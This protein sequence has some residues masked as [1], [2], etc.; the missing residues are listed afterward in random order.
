MFAS[1]ANRGRVSLSDTDNQVLKF[2]KDEIESAID[3]SFTILNTRINQ[4]GTS[5]AKV[6]RLQQSGR[7][8]IE[9]PGA[10]NPQRVRKLLQGVARLEFWEVVEYNDPQLSSALMGVRSGSAFT[11]QNQPMLR[12]IIVRTSSRL[13]MRL[14]VAVSFTL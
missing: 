1:A 2:L 7:I 5:E 6:Q 8:Q 9:I 11:S 10:D 3:R 14:I 12:G 4:F 13:K